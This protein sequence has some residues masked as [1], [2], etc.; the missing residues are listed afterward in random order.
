MK[1]ATEKAS[2]SLF[3]DSAAS[4]THYSFQNPSETIA[5][6]KHAQ[7]IDELRCKLQHPQLGL[8]HRKG[9]VLLHD[10]AQL[11]LAQPGLQKL[12][13]LGYKVCLICRIHLTSH[14]PT[15]TSSS[16]STT[17]CRENTFTTSRMQKMLSM[18]SLNP[19]VQIFILQ[20][21]TNLF[22][23]GKNMLIVIV[24]ILIKKMCLRLLMMI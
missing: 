4:M 8:A 10:N 20:E 15:S 13:E 24:P 5:S 17:F 19:E 3:G 16:I 11:Q 9:P 23:I 14:Q 6:E 21:Y 12:N 7:Q 18:S 1:L 2:W 22:L